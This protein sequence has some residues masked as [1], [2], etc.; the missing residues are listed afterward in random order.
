MTCATSVCGEFITWDIGLHSF[1]LALVMEWLHDFCFIRS[2]NNTFNVWWKEI[3]YLVDGSTTFVSRWPKMEVIVQ[4]KRTFAIMWMERG[5]K[6]AEVHAVAVVLQGVLELSQLMDEVFLLNI[7]P[8]SPTLNKMLVPS[9]YPPAEANLGLGGTRPC[10]RIVL[11][12]NR[13]TL[14]KRTRMI[15]S[16]MLIN[17]KTEKWRRGQRKLMTDVSDEQTL[18]FCRATNCNPTQSLCFLSV[19]FQQRF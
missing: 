6:Q 15:P 8:Q 11:S 19:C 13:I 4:R 7:F 3:F 9:H 17:L 12:P 18:T 1:I 2:T 14:S 10:W 16:S 5:C